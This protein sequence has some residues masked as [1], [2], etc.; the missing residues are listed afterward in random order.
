MRNQALS[1]IM[2]LHLQEGVQYFSSL[3]EFAILEKKSKIQIYRQAFSVNISTH[4][5]MVDL[6]KRH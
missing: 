3:S 5:S 6:T 4:I 1:S 2:L